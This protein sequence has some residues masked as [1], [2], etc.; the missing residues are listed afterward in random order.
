M[1]DNFKL[2]PYNFLSNMYPSVVIYNKNK[3]PT[4]EHAYQAAKSLDTKEQYIIWLCDS[5]YEAKKKGKNLTIREDWDSIKL[6]IMEDLL[7]QKFSNPILMK[8]LIATGNEE[9]IEGN[10]WGDCYWGKC[11]GY[12]LNH[13]G[14]LLMKIRNEATYNAE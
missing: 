11:N 10:W 13:L 12:G 4:V 7:R 9:L 1:I 8:K 6:S 2:P 14:E 3:Y 5:P